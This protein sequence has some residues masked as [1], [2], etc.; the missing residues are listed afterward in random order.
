[1]RRNSSS[2]FRFHL[3]SLSL[4]LSHSLTYTHSCT[5]T[6]TLLHSP[7]LD[8]RSL[9]LLSLTARSVIFFYFCFSV[10]ACACVRVGVHVCVCGWVFTCERMRVHDYIWYRYITGTCSKLFCGTLLKSFLHLYFCFPFHV[11][12]IT[13]MALTLACTWWH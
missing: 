7:T 4:S 13:S 1:M 12:I 3:N 5:H 10:C 6:F 8:S 11:K 2:L 9:I